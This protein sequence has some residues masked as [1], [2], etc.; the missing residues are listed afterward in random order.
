MKSSIALQLFLFCSVVISVLNSFN[1]GVHYAAKPYRSMV[2]SVPIPDRLAFTQIGVQ[3]SQTLLLVSYACVGFSLVGIGCL[4]Y[5]LTRR[6][7][8]VHLLQK[9]VPTPG[10]GA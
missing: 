3:Q 6:K 9:P 8:P 4:L 10:N 5:Y 7:E 1:I 2:A